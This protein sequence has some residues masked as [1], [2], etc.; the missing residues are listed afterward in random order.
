MGI[1]KPF[2]PQKLPLNSIDW[3]S[4]VPK[5]G[6]ANR[7]V[8]NFNGILNVMP[9]ANLL[10]SPLVDNEA[11]LSSKI[12]G[13]QADTI[14]VLKYQANIGDDSEEKKG[15]IHEVLNYK[16]ALIHGT[17]SL[18]NRSISLSLIKE[19]HTILLDGVRGKSKSPGKIR[20]IQNYIGS[21]SGGIENARYVPPDPLIVPEYMDN[22]IDYLCINDK[23]LLAQ[24]AVL[25]AQF[26]IIHPFCDGN[27]RLGRMLVPLFLY[28]KNIIATP[29]LYISQY[30]DKNEMAY[31]DSLRAITALGNWTQWIEFFLDAIKWQAD[32]NYKIAKDIIGY[33]ER[34]KSEIIG[35]TSSQHA[36]PL[37]DA[38]VANP[39]FTQ[40]SLKVSSKPSKA[41]MYN[42]L[43][44]L[45]EKKIISVYEK[46]AGRAKTVYYLKDLLSL[47]ESL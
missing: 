45:S 47:T 3:T 6:E 16:K 43:Q 17:E 9:N 26:E 5:M 11:V 21:K 39:M 44:K 10:L 37:L 8:S 19:L 2:I 20:E 14:D 24:T 22:F 29:S 25:H 31:K 33:Y 34:T 30:L 41:T 4:L 35:A 15:D 18:E 7:A 36:V 1:M 23:D 46:G 40:S 27:G 12:E 28:K 13:T 42:L 38:M 32:K